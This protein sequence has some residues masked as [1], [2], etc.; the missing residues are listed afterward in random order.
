MMIFKQSAESLSVL[1]TQAGSDLFI[2]EQVK[3]KGYTSF[4]KVREKKGI[5]FTGVAHENTEYRIKHFFVVKSLFVSYS[6]IKSSPSL[7]IL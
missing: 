4:E 6:H 1:H 7:S 3:V 2:D 5:A